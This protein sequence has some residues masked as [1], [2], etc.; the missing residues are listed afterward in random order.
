MFLLK[1]IAVASLGLAFALALKSKSQSEKAKKA[2]VEYSIGTFL[3]GDRN[4]II[5]TYIVL[6]LAMLVFGPLLDPHVILTRDKDVTFFFDL[7]TIKISVVYEIFLLSVF[8]TVGYSG[9]DI[10]LRFFGKTNSFINNAIDYKTTIADTANGTL[11]KP[12]PVK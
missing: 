1:L 3:L 8:A 4:T 7:F 2:N 6:A 5:T 11:D 12:T 10:A 9:M